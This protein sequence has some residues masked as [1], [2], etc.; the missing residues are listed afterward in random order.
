MR[1]QARQ[2]PPGQREAAPFRRVAGANASD[3]PRRPDRRRARSRARCP[4]PAAG[5][6]RKV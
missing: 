5:P 3:R 4:D 1:P 2:R 6:D